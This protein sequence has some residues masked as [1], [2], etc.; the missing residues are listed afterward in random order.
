ME[1]YRRDFFD[2]GKTTFLNCAYHGPLPRSTVERMQRAIENE[3][4]PTRLKPEEFFDLRERIRGRVSALVGARENEIA[5]IGSA[6]QG[7]GIVAAGLKFV[8]GDEVIISTDNFPSNLFTWLNLRRLGVCVHVLKP[9]SGVLRAEDVAE[10][11][12][13]RTR[14]LALD[15][16]SYSTGVRTDLAAFGEL[17]HRHGAI[18]V[19]DATQGAG[20]LELNVGT[21]P[22]DVLVAAAYKWLLAPYG[23]GFAYLSEKVLKQLD[24]KAVSWL[25]VEGS[26]DFDALPVETFT[27][28]TSARKFDILAF[29]NMHGLEASLEYLQRVGV[30]TVSEHCGRLLVRLAEGLRARGFEL[31]GAAEPEHRSTILCF[32]AGSPEATTS[33]HEKLKSQHIVVSLRQGMIRVSPHLY[34]R[35]EDMDKLLAVADER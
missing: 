35:E 7:I 29:I 12:N 6:T 18:L 32:R 28:T 3:S 14:V 10:V 1:D 19:V 34:N 27:V 26:D 11:F 33:L 13:S 5:L 24:L 8:P 25:S 20:A 31:S 15:W 22:V 17:A 16:V 4:D 23:T 9:R 2:F 30:R 21:L